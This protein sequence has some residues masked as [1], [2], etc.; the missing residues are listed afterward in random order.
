MS[1]SDS[2]AYPPVNF[3]R[4]R[5]SR[6]RVMSGDIFTMRIPDGRFLFGRVVKTGAKCF[7]PN[8]ILVYVFRYLSAE[9]VPP[10]RLQVEDLL[11]PPVTINR[12]GWSR[13]YLMTVERRPFEEGERWPV[14]YFELAD[15]RGRW[16]R[17]RYVDEDGESVGRPPRGRLVGVAGLGNYRTL[18]DDVSRA[19]GIPL[20]PEPDP[21]LAA[22]LGR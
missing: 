22:L 15:E 9:P 21:R 18:D 19:L 12:L 11:I 20:V 4:Q 17:R 8:C 14:H 13:G 2:S 1:T 16:G 3:Q 7:G 6:A 10:R 5:P